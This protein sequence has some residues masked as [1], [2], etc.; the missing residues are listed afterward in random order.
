MKTF[1]TLFLSP[2][3][4]RF[5]TRPGARRRGTITMVVALAM[6][7]LLGFCSLAVDY[8]VISNDANQLQRAADAAA[9]AASQSLPDT[10]Q[11]RAIALD[12]AA[13][14]F[15]PN[16]S[17]NTVTVSFSDN[18]NRITVVCARNRPLF[19]AR[20]L[21]MN[22]QTLSRQAAA[23]QPA[24]MPP[25]IVPIGVTLQTYQAMQANPTQPRTISY[26]RPVDTLYGL[27]NFIVFDLRDGG[28]SAPWMQR[29]LIEG[30]TEVEI[31]DSFTSLN[32]SDLVPETNFKPAVAD[33]FQ[34]SSASPWRDTWTG[35]L[36]TSVG[37]R[38][39]DIQAQTSRLDNPRV[40]RMVV[41]PN[42]G[43]PTGGGTW[44]VPVIDFAPIYLESY[45][46]RMVNGA[47][48]R[49]ITIRLVTVRTGGVDTPA[50]LV[51]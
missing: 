29:Q 19:F 1:Q 15:V 48:E 39:N 33:I 45:N 51:Q 35:N 26:V 30:A 37:I 50:K 40:M 5:R 3:K 22:S 25:R 12:V 10:D 20:V 14:N 18:N 31:G 27:D 8:G 23:G 11:A 32:A 24:P 44:K 13:R 17:P 9:L 7:V 42:E 2:Y 46:E 6:I 43:T 21:G 41:N 49:S 38:Y 36:V 28:K 4:A 16:T 47:L 34:K